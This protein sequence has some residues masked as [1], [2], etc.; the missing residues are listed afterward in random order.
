MFRQS[1]NR[2]YGT[3]QGSNWRFRGGGQRFGGWRRGGRSRRSNPGRIALKKVNK[4]VRTLNKQVMLKSHETSGSLTMA[5]G[6]PQTL[7]F[8]I[9]PPGDHQFGREGRECIAKSFTMRFTVHQSSGSP[10]TASIHRIVLAFDR[11]PQGA[12]AA[13]TDIFNASQ[14]NA[15][16]ENQDVE[17]RG[18][19]QIVYD[20]CFQL[21]PGGQEMVQQMIHLNLKNRKISFDADGSAITDLA[22]NNFLLAVFSHN[23]TNNVQVAYQGRIMFTD[24]S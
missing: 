12:N 24:V 4:V 17:Q 5:A 13:W 6:T 22:K 16:I 7:S 9:I 10:T 1:N 21:S 18:R 14:I 3:A 20:K 15:L 23:N 2:G 19:F 8:S 11:N